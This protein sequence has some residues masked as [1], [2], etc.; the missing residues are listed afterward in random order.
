[1]WEAREWDGWGRGA[2]GGG[3]GLRSRMVSRAG[4]TDVA[5]SEQGEGLSG[6]ASGEARGAPPRPGGGGCVEQLGGHDTGAQ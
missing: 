1:M 4:C 3:G 6:V 2:A 5:A